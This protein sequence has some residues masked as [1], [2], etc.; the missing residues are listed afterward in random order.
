MRS[1]SLRLPDSRIRLG[2][3]RCLDL[4]YDACRV[5]GGNM[6]IRD[7]LFGGCTQYQLEMHPRRT[8]HSAWS[9][10][11]VLEPALE[12]ALGRQATL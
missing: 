2:I 1:I 7:I 11:I 6:E 9:S 4:S 8:D 10:T 12:P 5:S 3:Q